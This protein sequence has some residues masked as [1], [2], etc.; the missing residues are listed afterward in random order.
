MKVPR[1]RNA[2]FAPQAVRKGQQRL[3][4]VDKLVVGLYAGG[5]TVWDVQA[6]LKETFD[7]DVFHDLNSKITDE[8]LEEVKE[9]QNGRLTG[10]SAIFLDAIV[11]KVRHEGS[12][13]NKAADLAVGVDADGKQE[14]L[15]IWVDTEGAKFWLWV[16]HELKARGVGDVLVV[17][18]GGLTGLPAAVTACWPRTVVQTCIV[19]LTRA[20]LRWVNY[21]DRKRVA[22]QLR[23][24]YG[25]ASEQAARDAVDAGMTATSAVTTRRS[26][27]SGKADG[28]RSL[29]SS[30]SPPRSARSSTR[31]T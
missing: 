21:K 31:R 10:S 17:V 14:V 4:G 5:M 7:L 23:L 25:A 29:R 15:G 2:S 8:V 18:C 28:S 30:R 12:V 20:S 13:L 1:D 24:I 27:G 26:S 3:D 22:A 19:H 9:W 16:M 6:Q 11:C